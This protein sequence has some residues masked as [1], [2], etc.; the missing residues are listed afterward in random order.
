[1]GIPIL[2]YHSIINDHEKSVSIKSF[3]EQML[4]M[5]KMDYET[6]NFNELDNTESK[7]KF[8]ITFDDGYENIFI[9]ALPILKQLGFKATCFIITNKIGHYNDWDEN[10]KN[11]KKMKLMNTNQINEWVKHGFNI[12]SH[13]LDHTNL[14]KL[15]NN[16][17]IDQITN[18]KRFLIDVFKTKVDACAYPFGS[19]DLETKI[20]IEEY[21]DFAVTTKRS[22]YIKNKFN[23]CL[24]PRVPINKKDG[25]FKFFL[26]IRTPYEDIK[27]KD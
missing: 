21:Y 13:T 22:R 5:K 16:D 6:I 8:I 7:K 20:L 10:Q 1:M 24:L 14:T 9:N 2:M 27:F 23:N 3:Q 4:L 11:F 18:S 25:L 26:K 15:N 17:K 12:G 19:Y